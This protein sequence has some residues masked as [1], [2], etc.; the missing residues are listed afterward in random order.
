MNIYD[1]SMTVQEEMM[2]YKNKEEKKP[3]FINRA[4]HDNGKHY[5]STIQVDLHTGTHMDAPL[6]M[7]KD[8]ATIDETTL[9]KCMGPCK[10]L[11]LTQIEDHISKED[12]INKD[13]VAGDRILLKTKNSNDDTFNMDFIY[14]DH[15]AANYL[16]EKQIM[17]VGID[18]L[19]IERSQSDYATHRQILGA[20]IPIVEGLRL[21]NIREGIYE[22]IGLPLKLKGLEGSPIRAILKE[23]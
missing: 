1:I 2:V 7:L 15:T 13:I 6:H 17:L 3:K 5:E 4:N 23:L 16:V 12:L 21:K 19:G 20:G 11:D 18:S 14:V 8:G 10:V 9:E 22:F